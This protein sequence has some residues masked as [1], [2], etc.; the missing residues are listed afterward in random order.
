MGSDKPSGG[1]KDKRNPLFRGLKSLEG[2][3]DPFETS[4]LPDRPGELFLNWFEQALG[5]KAAEP[6]ASTLSTVDE[7]GRPD[8]RTLILKDVHGETFFFASGLES[9]KGRQLQQ[10]PH[11]A[12]TFYWP[13]LG[14]QIRL[15]G[16]VTDTGAQEGADDLRRRGTEA[17]ALA[18]LGRQSEQL[19]S[20]A[21]L[22]QALAEQR[23]ILRQDADAVTPLWRLF[24]LRL[25]EAEFW[26]AD[27]DR[28]HTRVQY[29]LGENDVWEHG[30]L[31]P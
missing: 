30:L 11:A 21:Q 16:S 13:A 3:F 22:D 27:T 24:A 25:E 5:E 12:L 10:V 18:M 14:R 7:D 4:A 2:P 23:E 15:R 28:K 8:A 1:G 19:D 9:R 29:R 6:H 20:K 31:W 26:Q 17:R